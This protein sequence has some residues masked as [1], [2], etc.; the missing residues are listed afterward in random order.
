MSEEKKQVCGHCG[1]PREAGHSKDCPTRGSE[2]EEMREE[3][4]ELFVKFLEKHGIDKMTK[5]EKVVKI[6]ELDFDELMQTISRINGRLNMRDK[7]QGWT[8]KVKGGKVSMGGHTTELEPPDNVEED[9]ERFFVEMKENITED[10][11]DVW[12]VKTYMA[13]I[14][15]HSFANGN[16][17][18]ARNIY[19]IM[20]KE[21][22][23]PKQITEK[24]PANTDKVP[25]EIGQN[26]MTL[27]YE[28]RGINIKF[29]PKKMY[30]YV[31]EESPEELLFS[32]DM[33]Y[34]KF[35]AAR[36][37]LEETGIDVINIS[38]IY[39]VD[40]TDEQKKIFEKK[41]S[42]I[43]REWF[44]EVIKLQDTHHKFSKD[45]LDKSLL[46]SDNN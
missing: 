27:L 22:K 7:V 14:F 23:P 8:G 31:Y 41:Y 45:I 35:L 42:D 20:C 40:L 26:A 36:D 21:G 3:G 11:L 6:K 28:A 5:E 1:Y 46:T 24:R 38:E 13:I 16:G 19:H 4:Y 2:S 37:A 43:R 29:K 12:A 33:S 30:E 34:L 10:N 15:S 9:L 44:W 17:R 39:Y 18:T 25:V 32:G